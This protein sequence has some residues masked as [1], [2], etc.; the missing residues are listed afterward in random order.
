M[1]LLARLYTPEYDKHHA[2]LAIYRKY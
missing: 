1:H 2:Q